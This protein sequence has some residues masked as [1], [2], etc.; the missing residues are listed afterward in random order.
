M[1]LYPLS[2]GP[3][4]ALPPGSA[5]L[6]GRTFDQKQQMMQLSGK[7]A[8]ATGYLTLVKSSP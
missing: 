5:I 8:P 1:P 6:K 4:T 2:V 7:I 3:S